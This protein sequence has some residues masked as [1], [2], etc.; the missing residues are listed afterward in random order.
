MPKWRSP[1]A[2]TTNEF[3]ARVADLSHDSA[4]GAVLAFLAFIEINNLRFLNKSLGFESR[5]AH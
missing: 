2:S 3:V 1:E 4:E 5:P